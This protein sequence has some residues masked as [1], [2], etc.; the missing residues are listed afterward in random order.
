MW[1]D[2]LNS[3]MNCGDGDHSVCLTKAKIHELTSL[4]PVHLHHRRLCIGEYEN[5]TMCV[6]LYLVE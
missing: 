5:I 2:D 3:I 4:L 1:V 6:L